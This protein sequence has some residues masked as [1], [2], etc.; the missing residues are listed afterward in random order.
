MPS[1][2]FVF[3]NALNVTPMLASGN[4][5]AVS[6]PP[7]SANMAVVAHCK[8]TVG[9]LTN[10]TIKLQALNPDGTTWEDV[11]GQTTGA[12]TA[13]GNYALSAVLA[14]V[15]QVRVAYSTTGTTTSSALIVDFTCQQ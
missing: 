8:F 11:V 15:K 7:R 12:I 3:S 13:S 10:A 4:S 2:P 1:F 14:G 9:S 5:T 6:L